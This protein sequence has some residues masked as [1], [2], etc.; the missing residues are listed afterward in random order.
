VEEV[1]GASP[2]TF[3]LGGASEPGTFSGVSAMV[4]GRVKK[5]D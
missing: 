2:P 1:V 3:S 4:E 5:R